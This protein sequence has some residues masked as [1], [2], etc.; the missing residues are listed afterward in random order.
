[1]IFKVGITGDIASGKSTVTSYLRKKG[2]TVIDADAIS[3]SMTKDGSSVLRE[4]EASFPGVVHDRKLDRKKLGRMV[5]SDPQKRK[6]L[7]AILHPL[8]RKEIRRQ[9]DESGQ[10]VFLDA[11]LLY[12]GGYEKEMDVV[13][14]L[15]LS[16]ELQ[17]ERLMLRDGLSRQE[18]LERMHSFDVPREE[19]M[20][21][22]YVIDNS[23]SFEDLLEKVDIFLDAFGL[24]KLR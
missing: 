23:G 13:I 6:Q 2:F 17:L 3:R 12:E 10:I 11:P 8:I 15:A 1:M 20:R 19:K 18:A 22:S 21:K 4:I 7:N 24:E 5:F 9:L 16:K 14:Y